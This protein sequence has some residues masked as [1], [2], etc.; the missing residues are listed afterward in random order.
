MVG[1][2]GDDVSTRFLPAVLAVFSQLDRS[3]HPMGQR[4]TDPFR[5]DP[6]RR[7]QSGCRGNCYCRRDGVNAA[8]GHTIPASCC[9]VGRT[10]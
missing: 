3:C 7:A 1:G 8:R 6:F 9:F 2:G 4:E 5:L 10:I